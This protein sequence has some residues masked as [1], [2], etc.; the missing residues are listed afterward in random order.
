MTHVS[1]EAV[2]SEVLE[3]VA[4]FE[5][6]KRHRRRLE[7]RRAVLEAKI[8][9]VDA[10]LD[11]V[12]AQLTGETVPGL[13]AP[14]VKHD[15]NKPSPRGWV[16]MRVPLL[17]HYHAMVHTVAGAAGILASQ[18]ASERLA[19]AARAEIRELARELTDAKT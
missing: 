10:E 19:A 5:E 7:Q 11:L 12:D 15:K 9:Q 1:P 3:T 6:R 2:V 17:G 8:H 16:Y 13:S 14:A 4:V 18:W